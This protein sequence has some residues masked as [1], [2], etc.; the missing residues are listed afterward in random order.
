MIEGTNAATALLAYLIR[1]PVWSVLF[2]RKLYNS[3][4]PIIMAKRGCAV[5]KRKEKKEE[6]GSYQNISLGLLR[7]TYFNHDLQESFENIFG[8]ERL[9]KFFTVLTQ[10]LYIF[11]YLKWI[12]FISLNYKCLF[13]SNEV[14]T[15]RVVIIRPRTNLSKS[16]F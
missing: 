6:E 8:Y 4:I 3:I 12:W 2:R 5:R 15:T 11:P 13:L 7:L 10:L 9:I 1:W 14:Y 16:E